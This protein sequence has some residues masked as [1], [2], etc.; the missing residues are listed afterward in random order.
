MAPTPETV[1]VYTID[2]SAHPIS[3]VLVRVYTYPA[4][5]FVTQAYSVLVGPDSYADFMVDGNDPA[6][7]YEIRLS[8]TG[9]AYDGSA[10]EDSW[11]PQLIDVYSPPSSAPSGTN[12][13]RIPGQTFTMPTSP[14]TR[15]CRASGFFRDGAGRPYANVEIFFI[16]QF[17]PAIVDG[18]AIIGE[19]IFLR[20]D[21]A[22]YAQVDLFRN[23]QYRA[24]LQSLE[25]FTK[26][27]VVPDRASVSI[28]DLLFPV[29]TKIDWDPSAVSVAVGE[30]QEL[31]TTVTAS[32]FR[33][34]TGTALEDVAYEIEDPTIAGI[35][36]LTDKLVI[37]GLQP[38]TTNLKATRMDQTVVVIPS[39]DIVNYLLPI[40]V[41]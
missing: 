9:V 12:W 16:A 40:T 38:G 14:D 20:T 15:L 29:V 23:G 10:G 34:L 19:R 24:T 35:T 18:R 33:V 39:S 36:K 2:E 41:T 11:S 1:R 8:K 17:R 26:V 28:V 21:S 25:D 6:I 31:Y 13:F 30:D 37:S 4:G 7:Q 27:V 22:G 5:V 32:D 3:G